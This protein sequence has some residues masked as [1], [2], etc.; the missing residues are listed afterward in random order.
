MCPLPQL[1][2]LRRKYKLRYLLDEGIS[3]GTIGEN[4]RGITEYFQIEVNFYIAFIFNLC[5]ISY[6]CITET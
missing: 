1:V 5:I 3:F 4:G 6:F 2:E